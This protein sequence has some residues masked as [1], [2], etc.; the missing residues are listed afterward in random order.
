MICRHE[1]VP[2]KKSFMCVKC[3]L[4]KHAGFGLNESIKRKGEQK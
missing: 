2:Y 4:I 3:K 1:F